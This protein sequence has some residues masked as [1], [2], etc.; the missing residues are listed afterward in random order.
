MYILD[1]PELLLVYDTHHTIL[2]IVITQSK[3]DKR[4]R[5][6]LAGSNPDFGVSK[7]RYISK[8]RYLYLMWDCHFR[9]LLLRLFSETDHSSSYYFFH[10]C[11]VFVVP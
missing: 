11:N 2:A 8:E 9:F 6:S 7:E 5:D 3:K 4:D 10:F 1:Y